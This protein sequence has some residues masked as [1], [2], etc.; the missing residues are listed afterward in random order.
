M[1]S[2][3]Y[4]KR[5]TT[6]L[7]KPLITLAVI[8]A[9]LSASPSVA[10]LMVNGIAAIVNDRVITFTDVRRI[11]DASEMMLRENYKGPDLDKKIKELRLSALKTLIDRELIIQEFNKRGLTIPDNFIENRLQQIIRDKFGGDRAAFIRTLQSNN[12]TLEAYKRELRDEIIVA[13]MRARYGGGTPVISPKRIEQYYKNNIHQFKTDR[14]MRI[15]LIFIRRGLFPEKQN[16]PD[17]TTQEIDPNLALANEIHDKLETGSSF[18]ELA[19]T[20]SEASSKDQGGDIGWVTKN[21][22]RPELMAAAN[23]LSKGQISPVITT[24]EGYYIL[25]LTDLKA[26][27]VTP[28]SKV[29][30]QIHNQLL[31]E[32]Q[33]KRMQE[34]VDSLRAKA[35]IKMF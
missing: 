17:G 32:E 28:L 12:M 24:N 14:E 25:K 16:L 3:F 19:R 8:V 4:T 30:E 9:V 2:Q 11:A 5:K 15:S 27:S 31:Q 33:T 34:W 35:F 22:L 7:F 20:Y 6:P 29:R 18:E 1:D 21:T 13:A 26:E 23:T 10:Q